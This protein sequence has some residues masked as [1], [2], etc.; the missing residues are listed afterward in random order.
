M[1]PEASVDAALVDWKKG[2]P[3][4]EWR[5][6][7]RSESKEEGWAKSVALALR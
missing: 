3:E 5:E 2:T 1:S 6:G 4:K 7:E